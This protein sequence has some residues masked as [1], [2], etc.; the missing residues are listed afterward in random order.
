MNI[1]TLP[2]VEPHHFPRRR[3]NKIHLFPIARNKVCFRAIHKI[4]D[5]RAFRPHGTATPEV[6]DSTA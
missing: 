1:I 2:K 6:N 4:V 3:L 5:I